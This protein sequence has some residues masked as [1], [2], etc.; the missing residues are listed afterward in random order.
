MADPRLE[1][2]LEAHASGVELELNELTEQLAR[3]R[4]QRRGDEVFRLEQQ[5]VELVDELARTAEAIANPHW[6]RPVFHGDV[7]HAA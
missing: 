2:H 5:V 6:D 1:A 4:T 3:A 7:N